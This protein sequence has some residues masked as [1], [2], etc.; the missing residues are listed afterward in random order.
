MARA[1]SVEKP[2]R[3]PSLYEEKGDCRTYRR[4]AAA[5]QLFYEFEEGRDDED[6]AKVGY[7]GSI[8]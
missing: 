6:E 8:A 2:E 3:K 4:T 7:F 1:V 5:E